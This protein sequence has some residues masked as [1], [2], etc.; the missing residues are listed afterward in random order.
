MIKG[1]RAVH[2]DE[3][4]AEDGECHNLSSASIVDGNHEEDYESDYRQSRAEQMRQAVYGFAK[5]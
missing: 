4:G 1:A 2:R 5:R 3:T